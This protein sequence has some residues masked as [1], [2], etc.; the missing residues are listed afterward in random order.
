MITGAILRDSIISGANNIANQKAAVDELNVFPVPDGDTGTNMSMT[1]CSALPELR[2]LPDDCTV[3]QVSAVTASALLRGARG[4][5]GVILSLLFRGFSRKLQGKEGASSE[6]LANSL[7]KGVESAY[8]AVMNPTE[9]TM[10]T[11]SRVASEKAA[12]VWPEKEPAA[13]WAYI[14]D[15]AKQTLAQTPEMLP[16]LKK[17]GVIDSGGQGLVYIFEGML[18]VFEGKGIVESQAAAAPQPAAPGQGK[19]TTGAYNEEVFDPN[20]ANCYC[21]EFLVMKEKEKTADAAALR[22]YLESIGDSV[23]VVDDDELIKCHVHTG[24]PGDAL[25]GA[26]RHGYLSK[27][28]IENMKEQF[29][30][31]QANN[32]VSVSEAEKAA[33]AQE[34]AAAAVKEEFVYVPADENVPYGFV[35][36]S[37]GEGLRGLFHDLGVDRIVSG[38][39]T[40]N[41]STEDILSAIQ[42][43][44][45]RQVIVLPNNKN[46]IMASEQ[47]CKLA[48]RKAVVVG[49]R[50][51]PQG[52]SAMLAFNPDAPFSDN[53]IAMT[54]AADGVTSGQVTFAARDTDFDGRDIHEGEILAISGGKLL[55]VEKEAGKAT[56]KL[57]KKLAKKA[58]GGFLTVIYGADVRDED[59]NAVADEIRAAIGSDIELTL[60]N[61]G[62]PVYY[63]YVSAE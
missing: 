12:A 62:Q 35:S 45:A 52:I 61:G 9:G 31:N 48:D 10:L 19:K 17:A 30:A 43:I 49:T 58:A 7:A 16:V 60:V 32:T 25:Q 18:Q 50:S 42:S 3:E 8:K 11:V 29:Y 54:G 14:C 59:A 56:V 4:N 5:S 23:V 2:K 34:A 13:L 15:V 39:Q 22:A 38:G 44:P 20:M 36:V 40:M 55:Y 41:P 53:V 27:I 37:S 47:A 46:I 24:T 28:K 1:I 33:A 6:D 21:T 51:I 26:L 57:A 63:Y